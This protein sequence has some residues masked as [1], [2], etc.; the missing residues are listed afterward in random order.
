ME[1][2]TM[3]RTC[4]ACSSPNRAA[5]DTAIAKGEPLRE[6]AEKSRISI[7]ALHRHKTHAGQA[8]VKASEKREE[9][10]GESI[11][12]RLE[13]LYQRAEKVLNDAETSGDGRLALASIREVRETLGGLFAL[14][15][16]PEVTRGGKNGNLCPRCAEL[17]SMSDEELDARLAELTKK[18][19]E[20]GEGFNNHP[21]TTAVLMQWKRGGK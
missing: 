15:S 10:I 11:M 16:K 21:R 3:P 7:S 8:I 6:I 12:T 2:L 14:V 9:S 1:A 13:K 18:T 19:L 5:I 20:P 17:H 4:L